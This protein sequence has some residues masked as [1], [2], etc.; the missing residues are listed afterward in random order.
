MERKYLGVIGNPIEHSLSPHMHN[1]AL[2]RQKPEYT[3]LPF[4]V[5]QEGL[6]KALEGFKALGVVG[7]NVTI[8]HKVAIMQY[9]DVITEEARLIGAVNTVHLENGQ[10]V[11]YNTDGIGFL[12]MLEEAGGVQ[13]AGCRVLILGT[14]GAAR[15]VA[16]QLGL[17]GAGEIIIANR[18][19]EKAE[20][21]AKEMQAK[22]SGTT[23]SAL[24]FSPAELAAAIK[25]VEIIVNA[26]P[27][28][29][30]SFPEENLP[31]KAEWFS[32][33]QIAVD[34]V[35]SP[36]W[37]NFLQL[38]GNAGCRT[39]TGVGMLLYQGVAAYQIWLGME[40]PIE[41]MREALVN[42]L[43][44]PVIREYRPEDEAE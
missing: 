13:A 43:E 38:A 36:Q 22:I 14:G 34:L 4:R 17:A 28:G 39:L 1:A 31:L 8:P 9:L 44:G 6:E 21:F 35:Y 41:V 23:Y 10:W 5:T 20:V 27:V 2:E 40:P 19:P 25:K 30:S 7:F 15:A 26:T 12:T 18:H 16:V 11:G 37:T 24:S 42:S 32:A 33:G 3:Y 29:M